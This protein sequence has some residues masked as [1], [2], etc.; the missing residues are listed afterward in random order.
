MPGPLAGV[1]V[2]DM[3]T[4][5]M[6]PFATQILADLGAD[7]IKVETREGDNMR[8]VGPFRNPGMGHIYL[9]A[10]RGKRSIV[11][12]LKAPEGRAA[13]LRLAAGA[14]VLVYNVRPQAMAR[15]GLSYDEV[16]AANERIVYVGAYGY[17][18]RG[19]YAAKPAY[20][21][22]IQGA[23]GIPALFR[24]QGN[25]TPRYAPVTLAD[26]LTGL[27]VVYAVCA[28]LFHR[29]RTGRGQSV[30]VPMFEAVVQ[31]V[32]GDHLGGE[33]FDP[34]LGTPGYAR[35][36]AEHRRPYATKDGHVCVLIYNDKQWKSFFAAIGEPE[37]MERDARFA[38]HSNRAAHI[39]EVYAYVAQVM[40]TRTT[41]EW[42]ALFEAADIPAAPM[43]SVGDLLAHPHLEA[44]GFFRWE[45]HPTE[46]RIR[47]MAVPTSWSDSQPEPGRPA[48]RLGEDSRA[49]LR[50]AGYSEAEIDALMAKGVSAEPGG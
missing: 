7:V 39:A 17:G 30:E 13:L 31:F 35:L 28:A 26:R 44:V 40:A 42:L 32:L 47:R 6:G 16:R 43:N 48:P 50:E 20:D 10:G 22:L 36:L 46:G 11:L 4:V 14:D 8:H 1:R 29:E 5:V 38:T 25:P 3:T 34:P 27:H 21:D 2:I 23:G 15:L 45:D 12:D 18:Q 37:R 41:A 49:V 9:H 33:T 24:A 19:P